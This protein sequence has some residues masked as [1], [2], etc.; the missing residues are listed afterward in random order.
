MHE[1]A[2]TVGELFDSARTGSA[3]EPSLPE[4]PAP[5]DPEMARNYGP[6]S[7]REW[8][9]LDHWAFQELPRREYA[10]LCR[11]AAHHG[12][13]ISRWLESQVA[14]LPADPKG[15]DAPCAQRPIAGRSRL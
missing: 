12:V 15:T 3:D 10:A 7:G 6:L 5:P 11:V 14:R 2:R 9:E 4:R 13:P 1:L 8:L